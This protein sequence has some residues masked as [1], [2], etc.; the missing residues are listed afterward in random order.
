M[1]WLCLLFY[2]VIATDSPK[3]TIY[4][5]NGNDIKLFIRQYG[6]LYNFY[7]HILRHKTKN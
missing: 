2:C 5:A 6:Y 4:D 3:L 7:L 1:L